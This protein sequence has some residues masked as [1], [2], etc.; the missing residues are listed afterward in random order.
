MSWRRLAWKVGFALEV[1]VLLAGG[2]VLLAE[3]GGAALGAR[4]G[5]SRAAAVAARRGEAEA[6]KNG[7]LLRAG[8]DT[9]IGVRTYTNKAGVEVQCSGDPYCEAQPYIECCPQ[10]PD[11]ETNYG[12]S[13]PDC[14]GEP[15]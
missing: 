6:G 9:A 3:A 11:A 8:A 13:G 2:A 1:C 5:S 15:C 10:G 7:Q 14:D 12:L 4:G